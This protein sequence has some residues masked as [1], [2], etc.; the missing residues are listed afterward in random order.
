VEIG[1]AREAAAQLVDLVLELVE[2]LLPHHDVN[3]CGACA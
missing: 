3:G 1:R 2:A